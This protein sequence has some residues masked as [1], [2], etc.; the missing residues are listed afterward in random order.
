MIVRE[1]LDYK[2]DPDIDFVPL[3]EKFANDPIIADDL[4]REDVNFLRQRRL[5]VTPTLDYFHVEMEDE[6]CM[7]LRK[8]KAHSDRFV[9]VSFA[10]DYLSRGFYQL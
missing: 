9:R 8:F 10:N 5:T 7:A 6:S 4:K 1:I 3:F 2:V